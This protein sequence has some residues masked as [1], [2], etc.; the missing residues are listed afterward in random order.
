MGLDV[1]QSQCLS[2]PPYAAAALVM[3]V[4]AWWGDKYHLCGPVLVFNCIITVIGIPIMGWAT[5]TGVRYFGVFLTVAGAN[6]NIPC[7]MAYQA[8]N[9]VGQWKRA[10]GSA[11]LIAFGGTGGIA[12]GLVFRSQD[13]PN[14]HPGLIACIA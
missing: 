11:M 1:G 8:N 13:A 10:M 12:G 4:T 5:N 7:V 2:A 6:S 14:Y 9:I 3:F